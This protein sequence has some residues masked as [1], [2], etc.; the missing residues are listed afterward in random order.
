MCIVTW[1]WSD[2][3]ETRRHHRV[4]VCVRRRRYKKQVVQRRFLITLTRICM[5]S[6]ITL[7]NWPKWCQTGLFILI[8]YFTVTFH[9]LQN[10]INTCLFA[11]G[12]ID[13]VL[14]NEHDLPIRCRSVN[15]SF[16]MIY[17][18]ISF[19]FDA[20]LSCWQMLQLSTGTFWLEFRRK[21]S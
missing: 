2:Y 6:S 18:L 12:A 3:F 8:F 14:Q 7:P 15:S 21:M 16:V 1:W 13:A 17:L 4:C 5:P 10:V 11:Q 20:C 9:K 19:C